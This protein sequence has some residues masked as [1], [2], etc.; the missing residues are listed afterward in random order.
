MYY[1]GLGVGKD[2]YVALK[3]WMQAAEQSNRKAHNFIGVYFTRV[4]HI[5]MRIK[6]KSGR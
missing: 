1:N 6:Q 5:I 3:W 2:Y 4:I